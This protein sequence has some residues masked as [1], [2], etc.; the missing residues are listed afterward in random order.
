MTTW[1]RR[2]FLAAIVTGACVLSPH[3]GNARADEQQKKTPLPP[4]FKERRFDFGGHPRRYL[5]HLPAD[6]DTK[7]PVPLILMLHGGGGNADGM[8]RMMDFHTKVANQGIVVA[9]PEGL[10]GGF[11]AGPGPD[12]KSPNFGRAVKEGIDDV[13]YISKVIDDIAAQTSIDPRRVY[14][15]GWS[16]GS[17]MS[18]R[19]AVELSDRIAAVAC[20]FSELSLEHPL[21]LS[22]K[23][24]PVPTMYF[25]GTAD[26][27]K[28]PGSPPKAEMAARLI[29]SLIALNRCDPDPEKVIQRGKA[30]RTTWTGKDRRSRLIEWKLEGSGHWWPGLDV[31]PARVPQIEKTF[32]PLQTD[33]S[34]TDEAIAFFL[35]NPM[36]AK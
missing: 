29:K 4:G 18:F 27:I 34:A 12:G 32:G 26:P 1:N 30:Q 3:I 17:A 33:I 25:W 16:N 21:K 6:L 14:A 2:T 28:R 36:P 13:G 7:K 10:W 31:R 19:L 24:R 11:N 20:A 23:H 9:Y 22:A 8:A 15:T 5:L 35:A